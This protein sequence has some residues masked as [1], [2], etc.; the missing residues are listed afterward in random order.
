MKRAAG[1]NFEDLGSV[2]CRFLHLKCIST[3]VNPQ[4]FQPAAGLR[5]PKATP[6]CLNQ[7]SVSS[8]QKILATSV[9]DSCYEMYFRELKL[10]SP[11][12]ICSP[13]TFHRCYA[14]LL[15]ETDD[16]VLLSPE[17]FSSSGSHIL[18]QKRDGCCQKARNAA[19]Y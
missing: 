11:S 1:E 14:L 5:S 19:V 4:N 2:S 10:N 8:P 15:F 16:V 9:R 3:A 6:L 12:C 13:K 18:I 17:S 7:M